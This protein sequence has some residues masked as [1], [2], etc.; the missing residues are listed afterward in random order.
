MPLSLAFNSSKRSWDFSRA[1]FEYYFLGGGLGFGAPKPARSFVC[2]L[3]GNG[4]CSAIVAAMARRALYILFGT[5]AMA[6][7]V[8][9]SLLLSGCF[10]RTDALRAK[11]QDS[12]RAER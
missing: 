4:C 10:D 3:V 9:C 8:L 2:R 6:S 12:L 11:L 1:F 7:E 5:A